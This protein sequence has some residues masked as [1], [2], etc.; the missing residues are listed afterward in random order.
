ML[1]KMVLSL[2]HIYRIRPQQYAAWLV[3]FIFILTYNVPTMFTGFEII[4]R[5]VEDL[6]REHY[7]VM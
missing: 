6:S 1:M 5:D 7:C 2:L 4:S 3:I